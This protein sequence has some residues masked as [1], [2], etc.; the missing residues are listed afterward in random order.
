[1]IVG[2]ID[3]ENRIR[4][5]TVKRELWGEMPSLKVEDVGLIYVSQFPLDPE[6]YQML[7]TMVRLPNAI[8]DIETAHRA[9]VAFHG[10]F[11]APGT[12]APSALARD[13]VLTLNRDLEI[14]SWIV[15]LENCGGSGWVSVRPYEG[16]EMAG[17]RV[18]PG[19]TLE[20]AF[21]NR[22]NPSL[23]HPFL[24]PEI[25]DCVLENKT[26][27]EDWIGKDR[28]LAGLWAALRRAD[29]EIADC[30][31]NFTMMLDPAAALPH[32]LVGGSPTGFAEIEDEI[33]RFM[34]PYW[35]I[36]ARAGKPVV[37]GYRS[38]GGERAPVPYWNAVASRYE[39]RPV[40]V[41]I[42]IDFHSSGHE[43]LDDEA[44]LQGLES[45]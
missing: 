41:A 21:Y 24:D 2:V 4:R 11:F 27:S 44:V 13:F 15:A 40:T 39:R 12:E 30:G 6:R 22:I 8:E 42:A 32:I 29:P 7:R 18:E 9:V 19:E 36:L 10:D 3:K 33:N 38:K 35:P 23:G 26:D 25:R 5:V 31:R 16:K 34:A 43:A 28:Y 37:H 17:F 1:M 20:S 14:Q 45:Q